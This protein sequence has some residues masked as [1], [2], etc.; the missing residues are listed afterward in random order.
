LGLALDVKTL[1]AGRCEFRLSWNQGSDSL[2]ASV[3]VQLSHATRA[4]DQQL[5]AE[6]LGDGH[7][8]AAPAALAAGP[9]YVDV[10]TPEWRVVARTVVD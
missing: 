4:G 5:L 2:P 3:P 1:T 9:W 6:H 7:Y 10:A 8:R